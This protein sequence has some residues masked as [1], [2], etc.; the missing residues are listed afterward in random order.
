MYVCPIDEAALP[1]IRRNIAKLFPKIL[2]IANPVLMESSLPDFSGKLLPDFMRKATLDALSAA[3]DSLALGWGQQHMQMF[4][5]D[6]EP[7][8]VIP[9]LISIMEES[10]DQQLGIFR[11]N[12][13][14]APL[15]GR[16][17][18]RVGFHSRLRK[19]YLWG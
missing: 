7:M 13:Q 2:G 3:L 10:L 12:E 19:A 11:P 17:G 15:V 18:E 1:R 14:R 4:R 5:H 8:Q 9:T 6:N 16:S